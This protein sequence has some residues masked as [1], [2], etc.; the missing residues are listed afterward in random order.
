MGVSNNV[1]TECNQKAQ[2]TVNNHFPQ[3][4]SQS[5]LPWFWFQARTFLC[6]QSQSFRSQ[7]TKTFS[8]SLVWSRDPTAPCSTYKCSQDNAPY[9][10][11]QAFWSILESSDKRCSLYVHPA[12]AQSRHSMIM[13]HSNSNIS[14]HLARSM[15]ANVHPHTQESTSQSPSGDVIHHQFAHCHPVTFWMSVHNLPPST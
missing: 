6:T 8:L 12:S 5:R 4:P 15:L 2:S 9:H 7:P 14:P 10:R 3:G 1:A 11:A 13:P